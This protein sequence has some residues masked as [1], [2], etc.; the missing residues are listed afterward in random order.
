MSVMSSSD[1]MSLYFFPVALKKI[2]PES[3]PTFNLYLQVNGRFVLYRNKNLVIS[4]MDIARLIETGNEVLFVHNN[5]RKKYREYL[6]SGLPQTMESPSVPVKRKA[7]V[8]YEAAVN[9]ISDVFA[10]P[11]SE[12]VVKRSKEIVRQTVDFILNTNDALQNLLLIREHD[13]Y[14]FTHS[15]NVCTFLVALA[16]EKGIHDQ[17]VLREIGEGGLLHDLGKSMVPAEIINKHGP[18]NKSEWEI[19]KN[20]PEYGCKICRES[21][22]ISDLSLC[23]ISQH[24]EKL[25]GTGYPEGKADSELSVFARMVSIVDVYDAVTTNRSY[26]RAHS[27]LEA[28]K[29]LLSKKEELDEQLLKTFIKMI[30]KK[31]EKQ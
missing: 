2:S 18:L 10:D 3:V 1:K 4:S 6:E 23:I 7:E 22:Q 26:Q 15:V 16:K 5:E 31:Q 11:R 21:R 19:M 17:K 9:V 13:F 20:H 27:P 12:I 24:H 14:T 28:A 30:G 8:L 29:I 25:N